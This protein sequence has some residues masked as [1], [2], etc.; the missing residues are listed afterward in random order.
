MP[1]THTF[2]LPPFLPLDSLQKLRAGSNQAGEGLP[3]VVRCGGEAAPSG[4]LVNGCGRPSMAAARLPAHRLFLPTA[5]LADAA[6]AGRRGRQL[7]SGTTHQRRP[8]AKAPSPPQHGPAPRLGRCCDSPL[9]LQRRP[10]EGQAD[11]GCA[12]RLW[13]WHKPGDGPAPSGRC[14]RMSVSDWPLPG[15]WEPPSLLGRH[16]GSMRP[17]AAAQGRCAPV[18]Q[19]QHAWKRPLAAQQSAMGH[20]GA[21]PRAAGAAHPWLL[22]AWPARMLPLRLLDTRNFLR[23]HAALQTPQARL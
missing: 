21:R 3:L 4:L 9:P 10:T 7:C 18:A 14:F 13:H 5:I 1:S 11:W 6:A 8:A 12:G 19:Q 23:V 17:T 15:P 2:F 16:A 20:G 22:A